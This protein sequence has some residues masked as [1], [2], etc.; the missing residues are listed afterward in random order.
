MKDEIILAI[1]CR[2]AKC[3]D[4]D[5]FEFRTLKPGSKVIVICSNCGTHHELKVGKQRPATLNFSVK[6]D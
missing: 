3:K 1:T 5:S 6:D 2:N 4:P